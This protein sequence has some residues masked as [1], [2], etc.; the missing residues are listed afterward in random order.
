MYKF[1]GVQFKILAPVIGTVALSVVIGILVLE[2]NFRQLR[3]EVVPE[4]RNLSRLHTTA[5]LLLNEYREYALVPSQDAL[6][7]INTLLS[8]LQAYQ[9]FAEQVA[10]EDEGVSRETLTRAVADLQR[11][12]AEIIRVRDRVSGLLARLE[13]TESALVDT[14]Q[15]AQRVMLKTAAKPP[16]STRPADATWSETVNGLSAMTRLLNGTRLYLFALR[17]AAGR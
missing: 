6:A 11:S 2:W 14:L 10:H 15:S 1:A 7:D 8:Q 17:E 3:D 4:E 9:G 13:Q 12:G 16:A 5:V